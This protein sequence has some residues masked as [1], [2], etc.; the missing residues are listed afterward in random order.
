MASGK[1]EAVE[2]SIEANCGAV[3]VKSV[4]IKSCSWKVTRSQDLLSVL[5]EIFLFL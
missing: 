4:T 2:P 3:W 1:R 5:H